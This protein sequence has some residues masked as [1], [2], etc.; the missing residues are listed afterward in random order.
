MLNQLTFVLNFLHEKEI[1]SSM[2]CLVLHEE[3]DCGTVKQCSYS[4]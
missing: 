1:S 4:L 3:Q 2:S